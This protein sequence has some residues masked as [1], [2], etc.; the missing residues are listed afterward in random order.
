MQ[1]IGSK[2]NVFCVRV[3]LALQRYFD[4]ITNYMMYLES[5]FNLARM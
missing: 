4:D 5:H 3:Y 1:T 2:D